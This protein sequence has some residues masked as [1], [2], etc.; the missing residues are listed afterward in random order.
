MPVGLAQNLSQLDE[1]I[2]NYKMEGGNFLNFY[3]KIV[4]YEK[5]GG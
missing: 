4:G 3:V 5:E 2:E 1:N